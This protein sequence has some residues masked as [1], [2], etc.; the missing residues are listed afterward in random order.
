MWGR[1]GASDRIAGGKDINVVIGVG[2]ERVEV[3]PTCDVGTIET[4]QGLSMKS[5]S[6]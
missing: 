2:I 6:R 3:Q 5:A 1:R 4:R